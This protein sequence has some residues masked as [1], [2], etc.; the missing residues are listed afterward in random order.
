MC[1]VPHWDCT[2]AAELTCDACESRKPPPPRNR[3]TAEYETKLRNQ[4]G[5][6]CTDMTLAATEAVATVLVMVVAASQMA[7]TA[8]LCVRADGQRQRRRVCSRTYV[9]HIIQDLAQSFSIQKVVL[10]HVN[11]LERS[12]G[13]T[14]LLIQ[15]LDKHIINLAI[16]RG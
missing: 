3:V 13:W 12:R 4:V 2:R 8:V 10:C 6:E 5:L 15:Q 1:R 11:G 7:V 14:S 16:L 9:W